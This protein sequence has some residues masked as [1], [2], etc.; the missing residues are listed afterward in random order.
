MYLIILGAGPVGMSLTDIALEDGHDVALIEE[1]EARCQT[2]ADRHDCLVLHADIAKGGILQEADVERADA[3]VATTDDD[4]ANLMSM[5]LGADYG[6]PNLVSVVNYPRHRALFERLNVH[7]LVD[8]EDI[9]AQHLYGLLR[10]PRLEDVVTLPGGAE[11]FEVTLGASSPLAGKAL[12]Q[13]DEEG[14]LPQNTLV[15]ALRRDEESQI[16]SG[17]TVLEAGDRLTVFS[18]RA[19]DDADLKPFTG[20]GA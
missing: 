19:L 17:E 13:A 5:F 8:P 2:A 11:V 6:V 3:L 10:Q 16:P 9:V 1:D 14:L 15:V 7:V 4:S 12:V 20:E 18:Q